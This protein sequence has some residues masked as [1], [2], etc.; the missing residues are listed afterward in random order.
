M[1]RPRTTNLM[2]ALQRGEYVVDP[3]AVAAAILR[4]RARR[5]RSRVL[6]SPQVWADVPVGADQGEP[7]PGSHLA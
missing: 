3:T 7:P 5:R 1:V 2:A 4:R 6:E